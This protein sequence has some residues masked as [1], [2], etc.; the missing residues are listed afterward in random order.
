MN[1]PLAPHDALTQRSVRKFS[2]SGLDSR[3][4]LVLKSFI[5]LL[6]HRTHHVWKYAPMTAELCFVSEGAKQSRLPAQQVQQIQQILMLGTNRSNGLGYLQ[7]P[8][9]AR[10][11]EAELNR[12]GVL[13]VPLDQAAQ[14]SV[15]VP[16]T[17][18]YQSLDTQPMSMLRWPPAALLKTPGRLRLA[19][20]M[21]GKQMTVYGLQLSSGSNL[22]ECRTF[23][24]ELRAA[25]LLSAAPG[26]QLLPQTRVQVTLPTSAPTRA[27]PQQN[28]ASTS[29]ISRIRMRLGIQIGSSSNQK[30]SA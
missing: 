26:A 20:L 9:H 16:D 3:E 29:L 23:F 1:L 7:M 30:G 22:E 14:T 2:V 28:K 27:P 10:E 24:S 13:I 21:T 8:L 12:L 4:E 17:A 5:R 18:P 6:A 15:D 19:T 11:L 25:N